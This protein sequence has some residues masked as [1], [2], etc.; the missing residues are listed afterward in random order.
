MLLVQLAYQQGFGA[1]IGLS[2]LHEP[3]RGASDG[4]RS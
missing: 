1:R 3:P 2:L 4:P